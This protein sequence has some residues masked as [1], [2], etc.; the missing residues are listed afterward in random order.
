MLFLRYDVD[1]SNHKSDAGITQKGDI[2]YALNGVDYHFIWIQTTS[3]SYI[4]QKGSHIVH[5]QNHV[6]TL[7]LFCAYKVFTTLTSRPSSLVI[8]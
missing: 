7:H 3:R 8:K 2:Y 5:F 6:F 1:V 4:V